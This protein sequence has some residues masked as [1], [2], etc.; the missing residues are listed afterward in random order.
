ML[1]LGAPVGLHSVEVGI[2]EQFQRRYQSG[3]LFFA[4]LG[5]PANALGVGLAVG[6]GG[7]DKVCPTR[8]DAGGLRSQ[9]AL[10]AAEADHIGA[11]GDEPR[12]VFG[13]REH[14]GGVHDD[15][16]SAF[17]CDVYNRLKRQGDAGAGAEYVSYGSRIFAYGGFELPLARGDGVAYLDELGSCGSEAVI[18]ADAVGAVDD[19]L[20]LH[21]GG[22]RELPDAGGV[23]AG[24][25]RRRFEQHP[26]RSARRYQPGFGAGQPGYYV[27]RFAIQFVHI[28]EPARRLRHRV[29]YGGRHD[30]AAV[31]GDPTRRVDDPADAEAVVESV[32]MAG[33]WG[34]LVSLMSRMRGSAKPPSCVFA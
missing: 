14:P 22:V 12:Q 19:D 16:N 21:T 33:H 25:A 1:G 23:G 29:N 18:V 24:D 31:H 32:R 27:A 4:H 2:G 7:F 11:H 8:Q 9:H 13:R 28:H 6:V 30:A 17:V 15:G 3:Y 20:V 5:R 34:H 10:A 26:G